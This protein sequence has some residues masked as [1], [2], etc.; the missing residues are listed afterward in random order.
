MSS[1][2]RHRLAPSPGS[3][4]FSVNNTYH[5]LRKAV[6]KASLSPRDFSAFTGGSQEIGAGSSSFQCE[7]Y[8]TSFDP[9]SGPARPL[10]PAIVTPDGARLLGYGLAI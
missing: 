4:A 8:Y 7:N 5:D 10:V 2:R 3:Y 9:W 1:G 6:F